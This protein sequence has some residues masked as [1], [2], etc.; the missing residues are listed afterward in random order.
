MFG[1]PAKVI[2]DHQATTYSANN[3][4]LNG[5]WFIVNVKGNFSV[6]IIFMMARV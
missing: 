3:I 5:H 4:V 2:D 1:Q 6:C